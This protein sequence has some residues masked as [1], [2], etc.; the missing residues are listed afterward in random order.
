[1]GIKK[2]KGV[3]GDPESW[4]ILCI[5]SMMLKK[6]PFSFLP[7]VRQK[8]VSTRITPE[9]WK[10]NRFRGWN[11]IL[12]AVWRHTFLN[13]LCLGE[14]SKSKLEGTWLQSLMHAFS[15]FAI[16]MECNPVNQVRST[17][18]SDPG[19]T[20]TNVSA[21]LTW[22]T[23]VSPFPGQKTVVSAKPQFKQ[24]QSTT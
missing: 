13:K 24:F 18:D 12:K 4:V 19:P 16:D 7:V 5:H 8:A 10:K 21:D 17:H 22:S 1:M 3:K 2:K 14:W 11:F 23:R 9:W 6:E 15:E 20:L